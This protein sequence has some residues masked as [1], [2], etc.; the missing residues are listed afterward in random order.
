MLNNQRG[1]TLLTVMLVSLIFTVLGVTIVAGSLGG[2]K[3]TEIRIDDIELTA[4]AKKTL[5]EVIVQFRNKVTDQSQFKLTSV[6]N[7]A[8]INTKLN[9]VKTDL[10]KM[11]ATDGQANPLQITDLSKSSEYGIDI[12]KYLTR[13]YEFS[14]TAKEGSRKKTVTKRIFLSPTPSFLNYAAG[15]GP[16]GEMFLNG[17]SEFIGNIYTNKLSASQEAQYVD[18]SSKGTPKTASTRFPKL[19]GKAIIRTSINGK[20]N[21]TNYSL[22]S[23]YFEEGS[24]AVFQRDTEDYIPVNFKNT[25]AQVLNEVGSVTAFTEGDFETEDSI[26]NAISALVKPCNTKLLEWLFPPLLS[27]VTS[28]NGICSNTLK[29]IDDQLG[30]LEDIHSINKNL[31]QNIIYTEFNKTA[32]N[33]FKVLKNL[34]PLTIQKS[35]ELADKKWMI[36]NGDLDILASTKIPIRLSGN[37]F[38]TGNL[39]IKGNQTDES[40]NSETIEDDDVLVDSTI[41]VLGKTSISNTNI[42][43]I[44]GKQ[45]VVM[46]NGDL[47]VSRINEFK[48]HDQIE[49]IDAFLYTDGAAE[50]YGVG[51]IFKINGGIFAENKLTINAIRQNSVKRATILTDFQNSDVQKGQTSRFKVTHNPSVLIDQLD[52][53][54]RVDKYQVIMDDTLIN[55]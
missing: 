17:A 2:T 8:S 43:G 1:Q 46:S 26:T 35:F 53:L 49:P 23:S 50:L 24:K 12:D 48:D 27:N 19:D 29:V 25:L 45:L 20:T 18:A 51:S 21:L 4:A 30:N 42:K 5:N 6:T 44:Q 14:Y 47:S 10:L 13:A 55:R 7:I 52:A 31:S 32:L 37:I 38:V 41:Y 16:N 15:T 40:G 9:T 11:T 54:P 22:L 33:K 39:T 34:Q 3:R 28:N 36:V